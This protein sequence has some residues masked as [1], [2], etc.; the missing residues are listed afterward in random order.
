MQLH[1]RY[2]KSFESTVTDYI[3]SEG[4]DEDQFY[5]ECQVSLLSQSLLLHAMAAAQFY[6]VIGLHLGQVLCP[7]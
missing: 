7:F 5:T 6:V 4:A 2:M 1:Q 3:K